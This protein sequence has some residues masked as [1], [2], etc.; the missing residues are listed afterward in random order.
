MIA[1]DR[2]SVITPFEIALPNKALATSLQQIAGI[3]NLSLPELSATVALQQTTN[4]LPLISAQTQ[5]VSQATIDN[6]LAF[7]GTG[8]GPKGTLTIQ[9]VLGTEAGVTEPQLANAVTVIN[10]MNTAYLTLVYQTMV[11]V[12][13]GDYTVEIPPTPPD[14]DPTY[15]VIIPSGI[16]GGP[17]TYG[18]VD[19]AIQALVAIANTEV[20][21]LVTAYPTQTSTLNT[22]FNT[23]AAQVQT[24]KT[25]QSKAKLVWADLVAN[26]QGVVGSFALSLPQYGVNTTTDGSTQFLYNTADTTTLGGQAIV[27]TLIQGANEASL[28]AVGIQTTTH[29]PL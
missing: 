3:T 26:D 13:N 17:A 19:S 5:P 11:N 16:P 23:I 20:G 6:L 21:N 4:D 25:N 22:D 9:D 15:E 18:S 29:I 1:L 8:T 2:L 10:T 24:D 27:A 28:N 7:L 12:I 14:V